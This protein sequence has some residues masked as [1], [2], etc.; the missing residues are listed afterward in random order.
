MIQLGKIQTLIVQRRTANG[1]YLSECST[2]IKAGENDGQSIKNADTSITE[3]SILLPNNQVTEE[4]E[5]GSKVK[6]FVYRDS[7]DR[8]I[9]TTVMPKLAYGELGRL[10][11]N[12]V[13]PI[14]A[15]LD[16]GLPKDL[17]LPFK[18]QSRHPEKGENI[19]V[20]IYIDKSGRLCA[21]MRIYNF[22][23]KDSSYKKGD[24]VEGTV[25]EIIDNFGTFVAVDDKYSALIP[26]REITP[27]G[28]IPGKKI[29]AKVSEVHPDG[30]IELSMHAEGPI[31][32]NDCSVILDM[33]KKAGG[34][35]PYS[36][37]TDADTIKTVFG[38]SKKSFKKGIG[39]LYKERK[40]T[41]SDSGITLSK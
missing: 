3:D 9:A 5:I 11:V 10:E 21:T 22:L 19:L 25:Y 23:S 36:D 1:I 13:T 14:G 29:K 28:T 12:D 6:V 41:I 35:L 15:F 31:S 20:G 27:E 8:P 4:M 33:L 2:I 37:A 40:L 26:K 7:K 30:K 16:W 17:F 32:N 39:H 38:L 34:Y 24:I 18:E